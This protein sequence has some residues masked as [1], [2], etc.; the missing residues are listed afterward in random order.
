MDTLEICLTNL[1]DKVFK[2]LPLRE[3]HDIGDDNHLSEYLTNLAVNYQG[4]LIGHPSLLSIKEIV[5]VQNNIEFL[6][7]NTDL[8]FKKWRSIVL[9]STR[10]LQSVAERFMKGE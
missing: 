2:L 5:D 9:R 1:R 6:K 7:E 8:D 10:L 3:A 4:A